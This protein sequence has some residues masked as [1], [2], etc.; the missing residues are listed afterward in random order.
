MDALKWTREWKR[1]CHAHDGCN[2]CPAMGLD[3]ASLDG[4]D[5]D[6]IVPIVEYWAAQNPS[7]TRQDVFLEHYPNAPKDMH[8]VLRACP[9]HIE[10]YD[11]CSLMCGDKSI[12]CRDCRREYWT[13]EVE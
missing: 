4:K 13:V 12:D 7:K 6:K 10:G 3:C 8:G 2:T 9:R 11:F 5:M 1:M